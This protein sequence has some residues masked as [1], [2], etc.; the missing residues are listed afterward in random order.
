MVEIVSSAFRDALPL[1]RSRIGVYGTLAGLCALVG[2]FLPLLNGFNPAQPAALMEPG[3]VVLQAASERV[4][5]AFN[6]VNVLG[7]VAL[8][9]ALPAIARTVQPDFK[10]TA[11]KVFGFIGIAIAI[12][13]CTEVGAILLIVPGVLIYV[14]WSQAFWT[15][16][17]SDGKNP[18][19]ESWE[20][21]TGHFWT[22]FGFLLF[23]ALAAAVPILIIFM[24]PALI[25][26]FFPF[27]GP[28][29]LPI[30]F[31]GYVYGLHVLYLAMLRWM[32]HLRAAHA[33]A[34]VAL[35]PVSA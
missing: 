34:G 14:K 10:M 26:A 18:F 32:L 24:I 23:S 4:D 3:V 27:L 11:G 5:V 19:G 2:L 16:L 12:G 13:V 20:I 9:F 29:L 7:L 31:L 22:T 28:A 35:A 1:L 33:A 30:A 6:V 8:F 25:A 21:T 17:L 15:Y